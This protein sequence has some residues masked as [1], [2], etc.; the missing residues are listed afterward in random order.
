MMSEQSRD[1]NHGIG[2]AVDVSIHVGLIILLV[3]ACLLIL[4]P[5]IPV[6]VWG[7]IIAISVYPG[8]EKLRRALGGRTGT[9]AVLSTVL[10]LAILIAP[11]VF[12]AKTVVEGVR[13]LT[14]LLKTGTLAIPPPPP[15][16]ET[17]PLIGPPLK[18]IWDRAATDLTG[19]LEAFA[20]QIKASI[21]VLLSTSAGIGI[22]VLEFVLSIL[23]AGFLLANTRSGAAAA[24]SLANRLFGNNGP[25]FEGL[26]ASTIR[27]VTKGMLGVAFI[28][29]VFATVGF[30]VV[31]LPGAGLWALV[32]LFAAVLQIGGLALIPAVIYEFTVASTMKA[33]LFLIWCIVVGLMDNVLKPLL[34]GRGVATPVV[35]I[36]LGAIGGFVAMGIIGLF[37]GP[38]VLSVGY[39]LSLAWLQPGQS[40][41]ENSL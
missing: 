28:Q 9:A 3:V 10:M 32:F 20:P 1:D 41:A 4:Y 25:E 11:V 29:S 6:V 37:V 39:K 13:M 14:A 16:V 30:L 36:F 27:S 33:V 21:S 24:R 2:H 19:A 22:T 7:V 31:K 23:L 18:S 26:V 15:S 40:S 34:L 5:F 17:W 8:Y 38:I 12:L 35:V